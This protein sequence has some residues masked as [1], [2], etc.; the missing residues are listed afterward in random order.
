MK[1]LKTLFP[2][3]YSTYASW[4]LFAARVIFA[5]L[6]VRHGLDKLMNFNAM[7]SQFPALLGMDSEW[8]LILS[9]FGELVCGLAV[10]IGLF[11]RLAL[12]P[13]IVN[14]SVAFFMAHGGSIEQGELALLYLL[15]YVFL[16]L[17]GPGNI[18]IDGKIGKMI[19]DR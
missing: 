3:Q 7:S 17:A 2:T 6:L 9:I 5:L 1:I 18:S 16:L 11:T 8:S 13:M 12:I 15:V 19:A 10:T 4:V 14:M